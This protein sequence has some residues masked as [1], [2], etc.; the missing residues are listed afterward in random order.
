MSDSAQTRPLGAPRAR[1]LP[2]TRSHHGRT[3]DDPYEWLRD[4]DP[5]VLGHLQAENDWFDAATAGQEGLRASLVAD[6][7]ARTQQTDLS[8]PVRVVHDGPDGPLAYWYYGRTIEGQNYPVQVRLRTTAGP[9]ELPPR[10]TD[11]PA[12]EEVLLDMNQAAQGHDFFQ[13]GLLQPSPDG[14]LLAWSEDTTGDERFTVHFRDLATGADL[15]DLVED[16]AWGG[17][18]AG[19][20]TFVVSRCDDAW[21]PFQ[22][23]AHR[24]GTPTP[25]DRVV[26][27]ETDERFWLGVDSSRDRR[28][29][30]IGA[31]SK[32]SSEY[33]LLPAD[34][35]DS[36]PRVVTPR[37][38][39]IDYDVEV[40]PDRLWITHNA[41]LGGEAAVDFAVATAPLEA[42]GIADWTP[43]L[44]PSLGV[45]VLGVDA[46]ATHQVISVR[47]GGQLDAYVVGADAWSVTGSAPAADQVPGRSLASVIAGDEPGA[48]VPERVLTVQAVSL[49]EL[50]CTR[51]RAIY[52]SMLDPQTVVECDLD[53]TGAL[54]VAPAHVL[55]R[56]PVLDHP[57]HGPYDPAEYVQQRL[58]ATAEDGTQVPLSVVHRR[59]VPL[60][61]SAP[62]LLYGYG[63]YEVSID[64]EFSIS[65]LSLLDRG[66]VV[67]LAHVRGGGELGRS[68]YE[69]GRLMHKRN[70]FTDFIACAHRLV[71]A[72]FTSPHRLVAEGGSAGGLLMGAVANLAPESFAGILAEVPFVDPLTTI[73]MP[74]LPLTVTEWEEWG[75]PLTDP[76]VYDYMAGYSPYENVRAQAYP[77]IL[78]T[79]GLH[80]TRVSYVEPAKWVAAL[81]HLA[82]NDDADILLRVE[83]E[84][85]HGGVSGRYAAWAE[86]ARELAWVITVVGAA[87]VD[88]EAATGASGA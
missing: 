61:G 48:I 51:V 49:P 36:P 5:A 70:T 50:D 80:D 65:R 4:D 75:D 2:R 46:Y 63:A 20:D 81:R 3:F 17:V 62:A 12:D 13:V 37:S 31:A 74:E 11:A 10:P 47:H 64:A 35:P 8:V 42:T 25:Q 56:T 59:D 23:L 30:V 19:N 77:R 21:R 52:T 66:F 55:R 73:L 14:H 76:A 57:E 83:M 34:R 67:A 15:P 6:I 88:A 1:R 16:V 79:S 18:W 72:G 87:G 85:G 40:G 45:R 43:V 58:W 9:D 68:W 53:A 69:Q 38:P 71:G 7:S 22:V 24:L 26:L 84:A 60:D 28:W 29:V 33:A 27:T 86:R 32:D 54:A 41:T 44:R 78:A 39:G 82:T